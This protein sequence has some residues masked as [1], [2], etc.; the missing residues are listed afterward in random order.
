MKWWKVDGGWNGG[1]LVV[2]GMVEGGMMEGWWNDGGLVVG[3][4]VED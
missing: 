4:M 3:G 1:K 2:G